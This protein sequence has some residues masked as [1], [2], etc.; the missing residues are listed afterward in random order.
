MSSDSY[1]LI[2][3]I[4]KMPAVKALTGATVDKAIDAILFDDK[5]KQIHLLHVGHSEYPN[6]LN[7]FQNNDTIYSLK[8]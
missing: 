3:Q 4:Q 6:S 5:V 7:Y 2:S 1:G 8:Y